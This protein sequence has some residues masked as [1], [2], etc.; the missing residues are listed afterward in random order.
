MLVI[1]CACTVRFVLDPDGNHF[2]GFL[3]TWLTFCSAP[4]RYIAMY[5][6]KPQKA[7]EL[8]L[9]KGDY[10]TVMEKC[11]DGWYKGQCLKS[12]IAGV[13]PGNYVNLCRYVNERMAMILN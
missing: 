9:H 10:Y 13:F 1:F 6:Y 11:Q 5:N 7:D 8:E 4:V 3:L 2:V 12:G